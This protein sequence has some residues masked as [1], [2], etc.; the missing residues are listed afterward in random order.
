[1][2]ST[3]GLPHGHLLHFDNRKRVVYQ[4]GLFVLS[5]LTSA[6]GP[7]QFSRGGWGGG[8]QQPVP[9]YLQLNKWM[10]GWLS[11]NLPNVETW[12]L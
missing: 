2:F 10:V 3:E 1:M 7:H 4:A 9:A 11:E 12:W 8:G 6:K 5:Y